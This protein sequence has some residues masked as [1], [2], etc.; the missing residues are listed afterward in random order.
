[1]K[2]I[3]LQCILDLLRKYGFEPI[4]TD[5]IAIDSVTYHFI[6]PKWYTITFSKTCAPLDITEK[7]LLKFSLQDKL[8]ELLEEKCNCDW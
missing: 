4:H 6:F 1:M 5:N 3:H 2:N 8:N 7:I